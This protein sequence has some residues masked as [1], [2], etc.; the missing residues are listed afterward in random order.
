MSRSITVAC[1]VFATDT[2]PSGHV[3]SAGFTDTQPLLITYGGY[4]FA[5]GLPNERSATCRIR[6]F[7]GGNRSRYA[8][9]IRNPAEWSP[10]ARSK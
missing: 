4:T 3:W 7:R 10:G 6:Y 5:V 9:T 2:S 8:S 1:R